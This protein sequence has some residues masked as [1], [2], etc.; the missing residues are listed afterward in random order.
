MNMATGGTNRGEVKVRL[1]NAAINLDECVH[2]SEFLF[3]ILS[4]ASMR[5]MSV[6][7]PLPK[8]YERLPKTALADS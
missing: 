1:V 4:R 2:R 7:A 3:K 6:D 5:A 8:C